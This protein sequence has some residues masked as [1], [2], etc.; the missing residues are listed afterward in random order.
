LDIGEKEAP[1]AKVK[2][3]FG[4][5][6]IEKGFKMSSGKVLFPVDVGLKESL[7]ESR[8]L[9]QILIKFELSICERE[10]SVKTAF[11]DQKFFFSNL[12]N[13]LKLKH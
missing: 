12:K 1:P 11:C 4:R 7:I 2:I 13:L 10:K 6:K 3:R 8:I 5:K 9:F